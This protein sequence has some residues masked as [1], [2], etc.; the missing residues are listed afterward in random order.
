MS[1]EVEELTSSEEAASVSQPSGLS[2]SQSSSFSLVSA[3]GS[4]RTGPWIRN[5]NGKVCEWNYSNSE[6]ATF[7]LS[8]SQPS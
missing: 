4:L 8:F 2:E 6:R 7:T 1:D 3:T 5:N